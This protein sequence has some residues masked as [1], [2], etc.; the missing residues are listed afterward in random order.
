VA[1]IRYKT[2]NDYLSSM[3]GLLNWPSVSALS[4]TQFTAL[5]QFYN[6]RAN[7]GWI[8]SNW[9][10]V[11]PNGEARFVGN[12]GFYPN[13]LAVTTYWTATAVTVTANS[14]AN[15]ADGRVTA[16]K[17]IET[18]ANSEHKALQTTTFIP[19][20]T[21]Q[22]TCYARAIGGRYL[23]LTANDGVNTY[24]T[25]FDVSTG[26]VGDQSS[27][28]SQPSTINQ[29]ANGFW[30]CSIYFTAASTAGSGT[31][32][33]AC[34][35]DGTTVP[36]SYAGDTAKGLYVWGNVLSQT[37]YTSP[38]DLLIPNDQLGESFID[39][40]FQVYQM[41]PVGPGYPV[42]QSFQM[43]PDGVQIIGATSGWVWNG[44]LWSFP[45]WFTAGYPVFLYY[46]KGC[47]DYSGTAFSTSATYTVDSQVLFNDATNGYDFWKCIV[48]TSAAESPA[49]TPSKWEELKL[50]AFLF[51]WVLYSSFADFLRM[52]AQI[53][54]AQI[55]D[56]KAQGELDRQHDVQERQQGIQPP[57]RVGTHQTFRASGWPTF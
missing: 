15:P 13:N 47:P 12:Q 8:A 38:T 37:T 53:E 50:P 48:A 57:F 28:V 31:F 16:S 45:S 3:G 1:N 42:P 21:Y 36:P 22:L 25:F 30:V 49:T 7:D 24:S 46:R 43:M 20:A 40:V 19:G 10:A 44:W 33:P 4:A 32:G 29:T 17:L 52:D 9:L 51:D 2:F 55:M 5:Q 11:C 35:D 23:Y 14:I 18:A 26:T 39:S 56:A 6:S 41:S 34:S 54:K 27:T